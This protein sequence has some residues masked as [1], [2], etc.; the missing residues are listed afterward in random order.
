MQYKLIM[1]RKKNG[2]TQDTMGKLLKIASKTYASKETGKTE[3]TMNEMF[4]ISN[5]FKLNIEDIFIPRI[6]QN[7]VNDCEKL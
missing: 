1:L 5:Y 3:F 2:I 7:G 4:E 6:L